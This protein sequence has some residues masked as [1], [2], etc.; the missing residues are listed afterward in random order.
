MRARGWRPALPRHGGIGRSP[1]SARERLSTV[2]RFRTTTARSDGASR[3]PWP[4]S[5]PPQRRSWTRMFRAPANRVK[6]RTGLK[7]KDLFHPIRVIL[8]G[9]PEGPELYLL[10]PAIERAA[11]LPAMTAALAP[12]IGC[13]ERV[14]AVAGASSRQ[15][16]RDRGPRE[17]ASSPIPGHVTDSIREPPPLLLTP[18]FSASSAALRRVRVQH[19]PHH[20]ARVFLCLRLAARRARARQAAPR[21]AAP[22]AD[23]RD[24]A[25]GHVDVGG[26]VARRP[27]ARH[28]SAGQHLDA[29]GRRRR[30]ASASPTSSTTR[31]SR[32]GR[33]T[34][35]GSPSSPIATAAT[36]SGPSRPTAPNQH[37]L[38]WGPFDDREPI[39]VARRHA[40]RLLLGPRQSAGQRLQHLGARPAQRRA[41][42]AHQGSGRRLHAELV[43]RRQRDRLR[44]DARATTSRCGR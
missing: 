1:P 16:H 32:R 23:R 22:P 33:P 12:V 18:S 42:A 31:A 5:S 2:F 13:R 26:G 41:A 7:G 10:V 17:P 34:A 27:D 43:A 20:S 11:A 25:R 14:R 29:A 9:P 19:D 36:T 44:V 15:P 37:K 6:D 28:R 4:R 8:T 21:P 38:T 35:S 39:L 40:H 3:R 30:D 24:G